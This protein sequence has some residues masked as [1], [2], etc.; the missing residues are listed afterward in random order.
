[1]VEVLETVFSTGWEYVAMIGAILLVQLWMLLQLH[2]YI[3]TLIRENQ[4][5]QKRCDAVTTRVP[6]STK[7][8][9]DQM[10]VHQYQTRLRSR[11]HSIS[12][13]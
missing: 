8:L 11:K 9:V 6:R 10:A 2:R 12:K 5:L 3:I 7:V 13:P 4:E 1:M